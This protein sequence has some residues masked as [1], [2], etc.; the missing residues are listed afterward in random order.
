MSL[1]GD[2]NNFGKTKSEKAM[3]SL[4]RNDYE[5]DVVF[6]RKEIA[7]TF[8]PQQLHFP[9]P[10]LVVE[11]LSPSTEHRDRG[12]KMED[13]AAHSIP[14]YWIVD[15]IKKT[16]E[17]YLLSEQNPFEYELYKKLNSEDF[18][19][20]TVIQ[21]FRIPVAA[22]FDAKSNTEAISNLVQQ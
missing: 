11:V 8:T 5:P 19:Q 4:T 12:I 7:D 16:V 3:V 21:G 22:I 14:E 18:I 2:L 15:T 17:Q 1:Y 9:A 6:W 13:Y 10:D 20:S